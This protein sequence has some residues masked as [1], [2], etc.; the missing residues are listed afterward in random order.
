ME[1]MENRKSGLFE[2]FQKTSLQRDTQSSGDLGPRIDP[3]PS[4]L[5]GE[6]GS[7]TWGGGCVEKESAARNS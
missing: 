2:T 6:I 1:I 3:P 4:R 5:P 7:R